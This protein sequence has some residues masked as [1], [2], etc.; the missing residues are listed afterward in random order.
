M[1]VVFAELMKQKDFNL[2]E[3]L[4]MEIPLIQPETPIEP[5][6][7]TLFK[8]GEALNEPEQIVTTLMNLAQTVQNT[9]VQEG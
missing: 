1:P 9:E 4:Q 2:P 3:V 6:F 8:R 7:D 5:Q